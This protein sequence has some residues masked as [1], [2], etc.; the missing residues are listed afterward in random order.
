MNQVRAAAQN[1]PNADME[2]EVGQAGAKRKGAPGGTAG[3]GQ[4]KAVKMQDADNRANGAA[5][6]GLSHRVAAVLSRVVIASVHQLLRKALNTSHASDCNSVLYVY[7]LHF[8]WLTVNE[9][10]NCGAL[11]VILRL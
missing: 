11:S 4:A 3:D 9:P 2:G 8:K 5:N 6:E 7:V 10:T 1:F